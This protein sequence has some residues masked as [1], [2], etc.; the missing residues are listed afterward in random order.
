MSGPCRLGK[1]LVFKTWTPA[2]CSPLKGVTELGHPAFPASVGELN[3]RPRWYIWIGPVAGFG[4]T[5]GNALSKVSG[6][7][8]EP[9]ATTNV[10][11]LKRPINSPLPTPSPLVSMS[12]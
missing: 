8:T 10:S 9:G 12:P 4:E 5:L 7:G 1:L 11:I 6:A 3:Q 2:L